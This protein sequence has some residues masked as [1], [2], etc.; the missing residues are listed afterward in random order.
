MLQTKNSMKF[1]ARLLGFIFAI[2]IFIFT[3]SP[4]HAQS[5]KNG[6]ST[7]TNFNN[8]SNMHNYTQN[9]LIEFSSAVICQL[10]GIDAINPNQP[11]L[12]INPITKK[13]GYVN[14]GGALGLLSTL[15]TSTLDVP[16]HTSDYVSYLARNFGIVK[17]S[18]AANYNNGTGFAGLQPILTI[19]ITFRNI[20][21]ILFVF[22]FLIVGVAIMLRMRIDPRTVMTI[23]N[24]IPKIIIGLILITFSY[25]IA[26]FLIDTMW[27]GTYF[28]VNTLAPADQHD[29]ITSHMQEATPGFVNDFYNSEGGPVGIAV[30]A[31]GGVSSVVQSIFQSTDSQSSPIGTQLQQI[32][33][34]NGSSGPDLCGGVIGFVLNVTTFGA[35]GAA[36]VIGSAVKDLDLG[37]LMAGV[38][39]I[40]LGFVAG[41]IAFLIFAIAFIV[42]V[43]RLWFALLKSFITILLDVIL[44]PFWII[45]GLV[46]GAGQSVGFTAWLRDIVAN[47]AVFPAVIFIFLVSK[48][49]LTQYTLQANLPTAFN[50][51]LIGNA[52][53]SDPQAFGAII[54]FGFILASPSIVDM[55]KKAIKSAN[56]GGIG[57]IGAGQA[58]VGG[59]AGAMAGT[60]W[61]RDNQGNLRGALGSR[62]QR[63]LQGTAGTGTEAGTYTQN[64]IQRMA[65]SVIK[66]PTLKETQGLVAT[67]D[68]KAVA[69]HVA[70]KA[71]SQ[72]DTNSERQANAD[73]IADAIK[74]SGGSSGGSTTP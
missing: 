51:P 73:A 12:G 66:M 38:L 23:Q 52:P 40:I 44:A 45:A 61:R 8:P 13:I 22:I 6:V 35:S 25:S 71:Q 26:G 9:V 36:C 16:V 55:V 30:R 11:C 28:V 41:V 58:V 68:K 53:S 20:S 67:H 64:R 7:A 42:Q 59:F 48:I 31:S 27:V 69:Q 50:P 5:I 34:T 15:I 14:N 56:I 54:A 4:T 62:A 43:F 46:P 49:I 47:L 21:Y 19:F 37:H 18:Y 2:A 60:L 17:S 70:Q 24:Q 63:A 72:T 32:Q 57:G 74:K 29:Y 1:A 33:G 65:G 10:T 39:G 3:L